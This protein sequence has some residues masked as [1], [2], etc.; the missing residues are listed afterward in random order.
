[1]IGRQI[2]H[3]ILDI[4]VFLRNMWSFATNPYNHQ[5]MDEVD[6]MMTMSDYSQHI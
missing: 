2:N 6:V 3:F 5:E 1:M 4:Y